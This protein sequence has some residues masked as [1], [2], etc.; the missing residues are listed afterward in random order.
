MCFLKRESVS[1]A[2]DS[3]NDPVLEHQIMRTTVFSV[4]GV[5]LGLLTAGNAMAQQLAMPS[6]VQQVA[7]DY[8]YYYAGGPETAP[9]KQPAAQPA[10]PVQK[11]APAEATA[12]D[13]VAED[14]GSEQK[15]R[16]CRCG[17]LGDPWT[18]PQ[19]CFLKNNNITVGGWLSGGVYGNQFGAANNGPLGFRAVGD[20][21]TG[22]QLCI[23]GER[24][25][26]TGGC[27]WDVGGRVDYMFGTDGKNIQAF[28][29]HTWDYGWNTARDYGS[30]IPQ[31]YGEI[32]YNDVTVKMGRFYTPI[33][34]ETVPVTQN[35]FYSRSYM[36]YYA[37]PFT[38]TGAL[39]AYKRNDN[40]TYYA[41]WTNGWDEGWEGKDS[42]ST[43]LGGIGLTFSEKASL[44]WM[45]SAG[46]I[47]L[48]KVIDNDPFA[49]G[50]DG[51]VYMN[52][53][54]YTYKINDRWSYA[55]QH[56]LGINYDVDRQYG[57]DN[58]WYGLSNY[59]MYKLTDCM[60]YGGR[61]EWFQ[62]PQGMRISNGACPGNYY[63]LT[64]GA[65]Y[66][67]HANFTIRPEVR[68]DWY[69]SFAGAT[70][71]PFDNNHQNSQV[72]FGADFIFTY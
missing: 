67:P 27:G 3:P 10:A 60:S 61:I 21:F 32:A 23:F 35:F 24:K 25:T 14:S 13:V 16:W 59:L 36:M 41:G 18:L 29:D 33:G 31:M 45:M 15:S 55:F 5:A 4:C 48:G 9:A 63:E 2:F 46:R 22:D 39:A 65:N 56:D 6:S 68:Y 71:H 47:G 53:I 38:H 30:A 50:A 43:F 17:E 34:Y 26:D 52:S 70:G 42:G 44:T 69:N 37:E 11:A 8:D 62:D 12:T 1:G 20:G 64:L 49:R 54:V 51:N 66:K 72:S 19:P 40:V 28:G 7:F 58:Q 57:V